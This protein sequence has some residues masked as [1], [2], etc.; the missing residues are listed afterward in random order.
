SSDPANPS[1]AISCRPPDRLSRLRLFRGTSRNGIQIISWLLPC[2]PESASR[3]S[4]GFP[5][6]PVVV[7]CRLIQAAIIVTQQH[8]SPGYLFRGH[9]AAFLRLLPSASR[10]KPARLP[11]H[12]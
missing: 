1:T 10:R 5:A 4:C 12:C 8:F 11:H 6:I 3:D 9:F 7:V 2:L